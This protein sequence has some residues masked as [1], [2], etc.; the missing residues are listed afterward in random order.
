M[1]AAPQ[2]TPAADDGAKQDRGTVNT[3][4]F[5]QLLNKWQPRAFELAKL[6]LKEQFDKEA[7]HLMAEVYSIG[8]IDV[9]RLIHAE[10]DRLAGERVVDQA[11]ELRRLQRPGSSAWYK[12]MNWMVHTYGVQAINEAEE[13]AKVDSLLTGEIGRKT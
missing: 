5:Q 6:G 10:A 1:T 3:K 4:D 11:L 13:R 7:L 2:T 12:I 9:K 8:Y